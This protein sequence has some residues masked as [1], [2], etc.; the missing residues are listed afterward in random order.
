[1]K[2]III[3]ADPGTDDTFAILLATNSEELDVKGICTV[4][5]NCD[6]ENA[7]N[8]TFKILD[9]ANRNDIPVYKGMAN[10]LRVENKDASHVHGNNGL[11][12]VLYQP[13]NR[14]AEDLNAVDYLINTIKEYPDQIYIIAIGPLTNIACAIK[15]EPNFAKNVKSLIIMGG[16]T[17]EGNIT[18]FAE[19]NFYKDPDAAQIVFESNFKEIIMMGLNVTNKLPLTKELE[20]KLQNINNPLSDFL[21]KITRQGAEFDRKQGLGGL[22]LN[23]PITISYLIDSSIIE[24]RP[25]KVT[26]ET[27]GEKIGKSNVVFVENSNC[28]VAYD[29]YPNK[30]YNI[31]FGRIFKSDRKYNISQNKF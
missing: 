20:K 23:D 18:P 2:K 26:I 25:A 27:K 4:A 1:M 3:D 5:G 21:Y 15:K 30:F 12:G 9:L 28:K 22:I 10:S 6:L 11:G 19:Y 7:T 24:L 13:I 8:N 17:D 31:L 16:S 29:V 14:K